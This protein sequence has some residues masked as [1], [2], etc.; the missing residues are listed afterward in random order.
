[1]NQ[2]TVLFIDNLHKK[3][4]QTVHT[5]TKHKLQIFC[6]A[7]K[8]VMI[9]WRTVRLHGVKKGNAACSLAHEALTNTN[10]GL[11]ITQHADFLI[12]P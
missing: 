5:K 8:E 6:V 12:P 10:S 1:M 9:S 7:V 4:K 3:Q 2:N 11:L